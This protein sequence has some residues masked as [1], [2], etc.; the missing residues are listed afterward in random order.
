MI[1][2]FKYGQ[3]NFVIIL[4]NKVSGVEVDIWNMLTYPL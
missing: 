3:V 4:I 1:T 2:V